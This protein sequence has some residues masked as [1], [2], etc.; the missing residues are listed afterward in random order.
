MAGTFHALVPF[1][2]AAVAIVLVLGL[3]NM[4][5]GGSPVLSQRLMRLR[6]I[7]QLVAIVIILMTF[8]LARH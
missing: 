5:R 3:A 4:V 6:V 7:L 8:L 2:V 1:A